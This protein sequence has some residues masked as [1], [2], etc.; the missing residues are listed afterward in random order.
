MTIRYHLAES[1]LDQGDLDRLADW[2]R[3]GPWLTPGALVRQ[4]EERWAAWLGRRHAVFVNSGSSANLLAYDAL[5]QSGQLRGNVRAAVPALSWATTVAPALQLGLAPILIDAS[6]ADLG[7]DLAHLERVLR[8]GSTPAPALVVVAP[9]A[10][11]VP[12][13]DG[14]MTLKDRHGFALLEDCCSALGSRHRGQLLGSFGELATMSFYF[15]HQLSTIEGG[16]V[17]TD[18]DELYEM[19][20]QLR[21]HGWAKDLS[22]AKQ[23]ALAAIHGVDPFNRV[24]TFY[25]LGYNVRG[26]DLSAFLGLLQ[27]DK[28][29]HVVRRRIENH[30]VYKANFDPR[31]RAFER[32]FSVPEVLDNSLETTCSISF[33]VLAASKEHRRRVGESL[34]AAGI[35]TRPMAAGNVGRQ[36]FWVKRRGTHGHLPNADRVHETGFLLPNHPGLGWEDVNRICDVVLNCSNPA[37]AKGEEV[38]ERLT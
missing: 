24:F 17:S 22:P 25:Q 33:P 35:E 5:I 6:L 11:T 3:T 19:L 1:T 9:T 13:M 7:L 4:C 8:H 37:S 26:T 14:L 12:D 29:E 18:D 32:G 15:G 10:G 38:P 36:P 31:G 23:A 16:M 27:M 30:A 34:A 2:L 20:L 21:S 28:L